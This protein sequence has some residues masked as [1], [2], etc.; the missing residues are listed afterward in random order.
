[1]KIKDQFGSTLIV[2]EKDAEAVAQE[3]GTAPDLTLR[4]RQRLPGDIEAIPTPGHTA[5]SGCYLYRSPHGRTSLFPG[6]PI[7][8]DR[9]SEERRVGKECGSKGKYRWVPYH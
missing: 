1:M 5:G 3:S 8:P 2:R 7:V 9:S 6:D 4:E